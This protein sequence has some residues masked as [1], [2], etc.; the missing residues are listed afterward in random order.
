MSPTVVPF[1]PSPAVNAVSRAYSP[2]CSPKHTHTHTLKSQATLRNLQ[3]V[4]C[5]PY[6]LLQ[7]AGSKGSSGSLLHKLCLFREFFHKQTAFSSS[8]RHISFTLLFSN[9]NIKQVWEHTFIP[10]Q[11][12][13]CSWIGPS[14]RGQQQCFMCYRRHSR[15]DSREYRLKENNFLN[16]F[17]II[18]KRGNTQKCSLFQKLLPTSWGTNCLHIALHGPLVVLNNA[19]MN[20]LLVGLTLPEDSGS[21]L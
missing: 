5:F 4:Q 1:S 15:Q 6:H 19:T 3:L 12:T 18:W 8:L 2:F 21:T 16:N 17:Q 14:C 9:I 7:S 13:R 20:K 11:I 10:K